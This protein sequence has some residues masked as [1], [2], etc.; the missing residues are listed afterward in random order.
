M[1]FPTMY[2]LE[3]SHECVMRNFSFR[4][5]SRQCHLLPS[6]VPR[7]NQSSPWGTNGFIRFMRRAWV[8]LTIGVWV[9]L[10]ELP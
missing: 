6:K 10:K 5:V 1:I 4:G 9:T 3:A 8:R 7:T 2:N